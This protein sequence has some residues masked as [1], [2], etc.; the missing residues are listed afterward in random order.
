MRSTIDRPRASC[1]GL[2]AVTGLLLATIFLLLWIVSLRVR[3]KSIPL[4]ADAS[5]RISAGVIEVHRTYA[6]DIAPPVAEPEWHAFAVRR[7]W[8]N[9]VR[10]GGFPGFAFYNRLVL[11][12]AQSNGDISRQI[13]GLR[14][15]RCGCRC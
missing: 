14:A 4:P 2:S 7:G 15:S 8:V 12:E 11:G 5:M 3:I 1:S 6:H 10:P 13:I 9:P